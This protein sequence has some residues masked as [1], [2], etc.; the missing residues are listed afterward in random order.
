[1]RTAPWLLVI[2]CVMPATA[3][4][5]QPPVESAATV[6]QLHETMIKPA[7]E[8]VFDVGR[9]A[10]KNNE[11]WTAIARAGVTLVEAGN[12]MMR[13]A[14]PKDRAKW[15]TLSRQL[16]TAGRT[17]RRAAETRNLDALMRTSDRLIIVCETCHA[18]YRK[19][20]Y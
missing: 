12:L 10:P 1:M 2:A 7:S 11:Q 17:A 15:I 3:G 18:A 5:Q 20:D 14:P 6:R 9:E 16:V 13:A 4:A 8:V 19:P